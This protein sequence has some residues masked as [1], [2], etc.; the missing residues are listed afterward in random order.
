MTVEQIARVAH[1]V[2]KA[3]CESLGD[4]TQVDWEAAPQWQKDSAINGVKFILENPD[5]TPAT[6]HE[7]WLKQKREEGW[8]HG[9]NKDLEAKTHPCMVEYDQLPQFQRTKDYVFGAV[10][11]SLKDARMKVAEEIGKIHDIHSTSTSMSDDYFRGMANGMIVLESVF[12]GNE[13]TFWDRPGTTQE[14]EGVTYPLD[15][16][17]EPIPSKPAT[18]GDDSNCSS[19]G[20]T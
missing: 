20:D 8:I 3:Y 1:Q 11:R 17:L 14:A 18:F 10:V 6:T 5:A 7:S 2:N 19:S 15:A 4:M 12:S 9:E 16:P 13:I